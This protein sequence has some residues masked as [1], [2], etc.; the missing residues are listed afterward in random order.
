MNWFAQ[1]FIPEWFLEVW[2]ESLERH[3]KR[4]EDFEINHGWKE[5]VNG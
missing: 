2:T 1:L 5:K 4:L 3:R